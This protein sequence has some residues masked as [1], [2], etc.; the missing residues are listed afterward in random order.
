VLRTIATG[1]AVSLLA[2]CGGTPE[3]RSLWGQSAG[4]S[5]PDA[6]AGPRSSG[7]VTVYYVLAEPRPEGDDRFAGDQGTLLTPRTVEVGASADPAVAAVRILMTQEAPGPGLVNS[8]VAGFGDPPFDVRSVEHD[9]GLVTVD[10]TADFYDPCPPCSIVLASSTGSIVQQYVLT[11]QAAFGTDDPVLFTAGG[12]P[13]RGLWFERL[14]GPVEGEPALVVP[15]QDGGSPVTEA[16]MATPDRQ[17]GPTMTA[18]VSGVV[19]QGA[20]G[21]VGLDGGDGVRPAVWPHGWSGWVTR[22]G[23]VLLDDRGRLVARE[24]DRL[25]G[26]GGVAPSGVDSPCL[27][28]GGAD[29]VH[30]QTSVDLEPPVR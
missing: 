6:G 25:A 1:L 4:E 29:V 12:D 15:P 3:G 30:L 5:T 14:R 21:C 28:G 26:G 8:P 13:V 27:P 9:D 23:L 24:G 11:A 18:E 10:F 22:G 16:A 17:S 20:D 2:G 19:R 7:R